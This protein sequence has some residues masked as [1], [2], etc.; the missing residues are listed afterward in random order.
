MGKSKLRPSEWLS[1]ALIAKILCNLAFNNA[2][3]AVIR[4]THKDLSKK[5]APPEAEP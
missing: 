1:E 2:N 3:W 5:K 4:L